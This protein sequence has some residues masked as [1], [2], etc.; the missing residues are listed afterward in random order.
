[1]IKKAKKDNPFNPD[2]LDEILKNYKT[3]EDMFGKDGI[4]KQPHVE[5]FSDQDLHVSKRRLFL[6]Y[7]SFSI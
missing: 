7:I 4:L 2:L 6:A 3:P 1:M 5:N